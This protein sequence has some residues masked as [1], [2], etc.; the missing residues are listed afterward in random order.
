[1]PVLAVEKM[2]IQQ[3]DF[4]LQRLYDYGSILCASAFGREIVDYVQARDPVSSF[5]NDKGRK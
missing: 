3:I 1:M 4:S 5:G 2:Y